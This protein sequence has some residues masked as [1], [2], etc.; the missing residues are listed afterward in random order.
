MPF[1]KFTPKFCPFQFFNHAPL[2]YFRDEN[3]QHAS[4]I[5]SKFPLF[6]SVQNFCT[7]FSDNAIIFDIHLAFRLFLCN[8]VFAFATTSVSSETLIIK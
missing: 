2:I 8:H 1:V 6:S 3:I 7:P 5:L 4:S